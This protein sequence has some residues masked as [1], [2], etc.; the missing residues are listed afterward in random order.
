MRVT[1]SPLPRMRGLLVGVLIFAGSLGFAAGPAAEK[2]PTW[3]GFV[4]DFL[5]TYFATHPEAAVQAGRHEFDGRLP[6]WSPEGLIHEIAQLKTQRAAALAFNADTLDEAQRFER[7][8]L[9]AQ[10]SAQLFWLA[11]ADAPHKSPFYY[12][13]A[14][15]PDVYVSRPY[16]SLPVRLQAYTRYARAVPAAL[17]QIRVN[18]NGT[19]AKPLVEIGRVSIGGL[20]DF[21]EKDVPAVFASVTDKALQSD[22]QEA[23]AAAIKAVR[24]FDSWLGEKEKSAT[25]DFALGKDKF[26]AMLRETEAVD[27]PLAALEEIG[28]K[29]LERNLAAL[30]EACAAYAPGKTVQEAMALAYAH[31]P[32]G[33]VVE[34]ATK[35]L[36]EL[37]QFVTDKDLMTIPGTEKALVAEAPAY[38]RWNF[39]YIAIPGPYEKGLP[40][41]YYVAP[42]DSAWPKQKQEDYVPG[43]ASLLFTSAHEVWP[44]HFQQ[45]LH[46]NRVTSEIGRDFVGYAFA[47]GWAHYSEELMWEAGF[48]D[49]SPEIHIGQ[50]QEA[51]LRNIRF[52]SAI[53]L[54]TKGM[55]ID[56]STKLFREQGFQ[57]EATAEQQARRGTF[58]PAYI[59]YTMGKLMIRKLREDWTATHGGR[60]AWKEF[61]D[62]FL[63]YGGP[64]IPLV[65]KA[66]LGAEDKGSLF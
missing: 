44:G 36:E 35:Q 33:T 16:A 60:A 52:I 18:L 27:T 15:D 45:F 19:L 8:Y 46:A 58:D 28:R 5:N 49:Q 51:L 57:D 55:T 22:F 34:Y 23:N 39:A 47:E 4:T 50:L 17:D 48:G 64:P 1:I 21:Y 30:K 9:V 66:M 11:T 65:R 32:N 31:K 43:I 61:H 3:N 12:A 14:L 54:H 62:K 20:A 42:P 26:R 29:D 24:A 56:E 6:N 38:K 7:D 53:G 41:V 13:D 37:R 63:S 40:S 25:A 59:N 10:I 2:G